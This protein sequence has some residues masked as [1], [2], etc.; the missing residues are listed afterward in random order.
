MKRAARFTLGMGLI[1][2]AGIFLA[3]CGAPKDVVATLGDQK[4]TVAELEKEDRMINAL[5]TT[6]PT[7]EE[8][9][10][11]QDA[12]TR[13]KRVLDLMVYDLL[14][15]GDTKYGPTGTPDI[16]KIREDMIKRLGSERALQTQINGYGLT[17]DEFRGILERREAARI[18]R[19]NFDKA[20]IPSSDELR[21][22]FEKN[23]NRLIQVDYD[24]VIVPSKS[25]ATSVREALLKDERALDEY[26]KKFNN[27]LVSDTEV[28]QVKNETV[29]DSVLP[30]EAI[31]SQRTSDVAIYYDSWSKYSGCYHVVRITRRE[32]RFEE[33]RDS[34]LAKYL[35]DRYT[36]YIEELSRDR[37]L[38]LYLSH[39]PEEKSAEESARESK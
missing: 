27:D 16:S 18:H 32:D 25:E 19:E 4:I 1:L 2:S 33:L 20:N 35:Q 13:K 29:E 38:K 26:R 5:L 36:A 28:I 14:I 9:E 23:K 24:D 39:I 17:E 11:S 31:L 30:K 3:G 22:Y 37:G 8:K 6:Q 34:T 10:Q 12:A 15:R 21:A 7:E